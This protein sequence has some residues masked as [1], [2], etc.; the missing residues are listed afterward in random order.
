VE[1][2][3]IHVVLKAN[4][5]MTLQTAHAGRHKSAEMHAHGI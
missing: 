5:H 1:V 3:D 4:T 2:G